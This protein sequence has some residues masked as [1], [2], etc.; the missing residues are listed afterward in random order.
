MALASAAPVCA[1]TSPAPPILAGLLPLDA[2]LASQWPACGA[3][4]DPVG[5][6]CGGDSATA[7]YV[8]N[9]G[10]EWNADGSVTH[11]GV[12]LC[13][14][15]AGGLVV[16]AAN[17]LVVL[18][19]RQSRS[20]YGDH[21]V[22]AHRLDDASFAYTVYAH[23]RRGSI[24]VHAGQEVA[25]G[26]VLGRVG[27]SGRASTD[28]LHFEIRVPSNLER[29]WEKCEVVDPVA[30][31]DRRRSCRDDDTTW[32]RPYLEW[33][34]RGA[35]VEPGSAGDEPLRH[36]A[37]WSMI[38]RAALDLSPAERG[39]LRDA[40]VAHELL[41][42][43]EPRGDEAVSYREMARD[44]ARLSERDLTRL[45]PLL[46]DLATHRAICEHRLETANPAR[47]TDRVSR[48]GGTPRVAEACLILADLRVQPGPPS[49]RAD[50][51]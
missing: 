49:I 7:P 47:D 25:A 21:V 1:Q 48:L 46:E 28:H 30:F 13:N 36:H 37:W 35:L 8:V 5:L 41:P 44:L 32:A 51:R 10:V 33:A 38:A 40:L 50:Q 11:Q 16:A 9:R 27:H 39:E 29:R 6:G 14:R 12:D 34:E 22:L 43:D 42:A 19:A 31:L 24:D 15:H 17:G 20:G 18:A 3:W 26:Q 45:A 4:V 2:A 23:L